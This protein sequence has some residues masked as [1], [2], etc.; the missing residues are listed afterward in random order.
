[1][2]VSPTLART[3]IRSLTRGTAVPGGSRYIHVGNDKWLQAQEELLSEIADDGHA[4][5]KFV[6][7]AYGSGKSHFLSMVQETARDRGWM[8][9]HVECRVDGVQ[10]DRFE[11]LYPK[12]VG[13]LNCRELSLL[14]LDASSRLDPCRFLLD[15][16]FISQLSAIGIRQDRAVRPLE[17]EHRLFTRLQTT[18]LETSLFADFTRALCAYARARFARDDEVSGSVVR[19]LRGAPERAQMPTSYLRKPT[20]NSGHSQEIFAIRPIGPG[21]AMDVMRGLL[22]LIRS[23]GFPGLVLCIDEVEELAKLSTQRRRDQALQALREYVD[24]AGGE[25]GFRSFCLYLAATPDMF[26]GRD[27]FPRYE[28]LATRIAPVSDE[29]NWRAPVVD[30]DRTPLSAGQLAQLASRICAVHRIAYPESRAAIGDEDS[31]GLFVESVLGNRTGI[32]KPRLLAR[33][34]V[35]AL[36][37]ARQSSDWSPTSNVGALVEAAART[38]AAERS[39]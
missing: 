17:A 25:G 1:M 21:T 14:P 23:A 28:A 37:R 18:L 12:L 22:W 19:W 4:D 35:D 36:E 30:L 34:I 26:D 3:L 9:S 6:R 10:I 20:T 5:T 2:E 31:I 16:W 32:A 39:Q 29:I 38:I 27:Y 7:G 13:K 8:T 24:H 33:V 15:R 11:T